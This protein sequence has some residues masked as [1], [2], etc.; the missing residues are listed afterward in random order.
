MLII[1]PQ[2]GQLYVQGTDKKRYAGWELNLV[3]F[4]KEANRG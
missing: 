1:K 3:T 2:L 4:L